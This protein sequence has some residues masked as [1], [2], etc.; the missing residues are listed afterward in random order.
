MGRL[1][2][3]PDLL[4]QSCTKVHARAPRLLSQEH[5]SSQRPWR[6]TTGQ[7]PLVA[8][9]GFLAN[10]MGRWRSDCRYQPLS[11]EVSVKNALPLACELRRL[12]VPRWGLLLADCPHPDTN[13]CPSGINKS[14]R[15]SPL[16]LQN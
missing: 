13:M 9:K 14:P 1:C 11:K 15:L 12:W 5:R 6:E 3:P 8:P 10:F 7:H 4:G 16:Q 2:V